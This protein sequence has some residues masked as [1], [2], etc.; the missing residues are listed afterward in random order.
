[1]QFFA[2]GQN[3][4][5]QLGLGKEF[6][7]QDT[8]QRVRSLD[9]VPLSQVAAGG[10]HS[11]ALSLSGAVFGWGKNTSGQLGLSD[12]KEISLCFFSQPRHVSER[13][14]K[15]KA[16]EEDFKEIKLFPSLFCLV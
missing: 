13:L 3:N 2:W 9:G 5:G 10:A 4:Y 1:G 8:P 15:W 16:R 12:E 11:F 6:P 14:Q 7:S